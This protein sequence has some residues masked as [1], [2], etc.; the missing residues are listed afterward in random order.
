MSNDP[1]TDRFFIVLFKRGN[2][3]LKY[4]EGD[5]HYTFEELERKLDELGRDNVLI[6]RLEYVTV[7]PQEYKEFKAGMEYLQPKITL[8]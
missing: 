3:V 7:T 8:H 1:A 2:E 6:R 4:P 5:N